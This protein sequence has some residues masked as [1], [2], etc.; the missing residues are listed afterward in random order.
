[1]TGAGRKIRAGDMVK[2]IGSAR[3]V[4]DSGLKIL[5]LLIRQIQ[6]IW[7]GIWLPKMP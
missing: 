2:R 7:I 5:K 1:M 3:T 6:T 4:T